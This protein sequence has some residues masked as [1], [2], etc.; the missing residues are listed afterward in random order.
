M[1]ADPTA[2][3]TPWSQPWTV[4]A[5]I[6]LTGVGLHSGH[7]ATVRVLAAPAGHGLVFHRVDLPGAPAVPARYD[8]VTETMLSTAL[9]PDHA[10]VRTVEH[11]L[12]ALYGMGISDA[13]IEVDGP[14][15]PVLDGSAA[16]YVEG[17]RHVGVEVLAGRRETIA[18]PELAIADGDKS[19]S[20]APADTASITYVV[21]YGHPLAGAQ[22]LHL[23]L[24][25]K[26]F[27][28]A[29]APA[30]T[31]CFARDVEAMQAAG[32]AKGGSI[33]NAVVILEDAYSSALRFPD[34]LVRHKA[35]DLIGDLALLG[36]NWTG[37][38][39]VVKGGHALHNTL[40]R[41]LMR[42]VGQ[43]LSTPVGAGR[44]P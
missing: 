11:L 42:R 8:G 37:H 41:A 29:I 43:G 13:R 38:V 4:A 33:E 15:L 10:R 44:H 19:V 28:E 31:F 21:D 16:P 30:R 35:L 1:I 18:L 2:E 17:I 39:T 6:A 34:E 24:T 36:A 3:L 5:P 7:S 27:A 23:A 32:L 20:V 12:A 26:V 14:E 25:P 22:I 40:A 9:G